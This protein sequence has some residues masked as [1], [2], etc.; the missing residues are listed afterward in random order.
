M[1]M[2]GLDIRQARARAAEILEVFAAQTG[3]AALVILDDAVIETPDAFYFPYQ[4]ADFI[5]G[6]ELRDA[7]AGNITLRINRDGG[8]HRFEAP[9]Q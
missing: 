4:T 5:I 2:S 8:E 1:P 3:L 6:G 9:P 7:L